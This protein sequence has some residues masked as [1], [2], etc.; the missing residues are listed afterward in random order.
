VRKEVMRM[1]KLLRKKGYMEIRERR[2][3]T[4]KWGYETVGGDALS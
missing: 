4:E 1:R 3:Y 2:N